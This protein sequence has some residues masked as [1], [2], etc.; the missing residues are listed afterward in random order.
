MAAAAA[1]VTGSRPLAR[2]AA[3][4]PVSTSPVPAVASDGGPVSHT[5]G[6]PSGRLHDRA[7]A[8]Q[9]HDG[10]VPLGAGLRGLEPV[11]VDPGGVAVEETRE[12][13]RM[14]GQHGRVGSRHGPQAEERVGIDD[15]GKLEALE[16][17]RHE[18]VRLGA[19]AE[20]RPERDGVGALRLGHD[21]LLRVVPVEAALDGLERERLD[22]RRGIRAG[23]RAV[24]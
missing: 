4:T 14:R 1:A 11:S 15:D 8:L 7:G 24:T 17:P 2:N 6:P 3:T 5:T 18:R 19:A 21:R 12:L 9:Q 22:D 10:A 16:Q 20:P 13:P 23:R